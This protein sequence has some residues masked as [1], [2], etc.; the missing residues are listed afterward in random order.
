M[1]NLLKY[2]GV[3]IVLLGVLVEVIYFFG[4]R[5]NV[6]LIVAGLLIVCGTISHIVLNRYL[7]D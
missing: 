6:M 4:T 5:S 2:C 3:I 7:A 1:K